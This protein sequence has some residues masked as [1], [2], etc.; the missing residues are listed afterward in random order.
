MRRLATSAAL[1]IA[2]V[3]GCTAGGD[4]EP[5][6]APVVYAY[7]QRESEST[8]EGVVLVRDD[9]VVARIPGESPTFTADG[10][11]LVSIL[12][13]KI[14]A[15]DVAS[16]KTYEHLLTFT[17]P[18]GC[19]V[20]ASLVGDAVVLAAPTLRRLKLPELTTVE[21]VS[22]QLPPRLPACVVGTVGTD[23]LVVVRNRQGPQLYRVGADGTTRRLGPDPL[24]PPI[25]S[26]PDIIRF[27]TTGPP[28]MAYVT[29]DGNLAEVV[30]VLDLD[31]G[32]DIVPE[33]AALGLPD[34]A[35]TVNVRDVWWSASGT[36]YATMQSQKS[37]QEVAAVEQQLW[38]LNGNAWEPAY[39]MRWL[40][41]RELPDGRRLIILAEESGDPAVGPGNLF[42]ESPQGLRQIAEAVYEVATPPLT[43]PPPAQPPALGL[44]WGPYQEGYQAVEPKQIA[45]GGSPTGAVSDITWQNWGTD[46][47]TGTGTGWV[48][49]ETVAGGH[50]EKMTVVAFD[51]GTCGGRPA[52]RAVHWYPTSESYDPAHYI[53]ACNGQFH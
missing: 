8:P 12:P 46:R 48:E 45:N 1:L 10:K 17:P 5:P 49:G 21:P 19:E 50:E 4:A 29:S 42:E 11:Y 33:F 9:K 43:T 37:R 18:K 51:L 6:P 26:G 53:D 27:S 16:G 28:R 30:H 32:Q 2:A 52:Y 44:V 15:T 38:Q 41:V 7:E 47:A 34:R 36:L 31:S 20:S 35:D 22:A 39:A 23:L 13:G 25:D 3:S 40:S 24:A 14:A